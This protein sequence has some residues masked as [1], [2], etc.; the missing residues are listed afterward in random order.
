MIGFSRFICTFAFR[1]ALRICVQYK[2]WPKSGWVDGREYIGN[3]RLQ[4]R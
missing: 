4:I 1:T 3:L 2:K